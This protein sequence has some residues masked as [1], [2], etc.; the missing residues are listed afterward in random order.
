MFHESDRQIAIAG[1]NRALETARTMRA[2]ASWCTP[3]DIRFV[4]P[5]PN[6]PHEVNAFVE[7]P[8]GGLPVKYELDQKIRR[9]VRRPLPAHVDAL[10]EQLRLHPEHARRRRRSARHSR[11]DTDAGGRRLR[12]PLTS[13]R[14]AADG[15]RKGRRRENPRRAGGCAQPVLQG[16][17]D[18]PTTCRRC[19]WS[20]SRTSSRTTK[21]SS[22]ASAPASANGRHSR[23]R[24]NAS[25]WRS[26]ARDD[27]G[28]GGAALRIKSAPTAI[29]GAARL[30]SRRSS[31]AT[32]SSSRDPPSRSTE[33]ASRASSRALLPNRGS[34]QRDRA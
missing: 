20:R 9:A 16:R 28:S 23:S 19:W 24:T 30:L 10:P 12:D 25:T 5:G 34:S 11:G 4:S 33:A 2:S 3:M 22:P 15:R 13:G 8:Q 1:W 21:I 17:E 29:H 31:S 18:A 14:R 7:I 26:R 32:A 27:K 6:P